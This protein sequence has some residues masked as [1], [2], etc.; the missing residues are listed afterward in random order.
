MPHPS[1]PV[2]CTDCAFAWNSATMVDGL[3]L[4]GSCP[5]CG[6]ALSFRDPEPDQDRADE[7]AA[8][9]RS[10][11]ERAPHLVLGLPRR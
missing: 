10:T 9:H 8:P 5:R 2:S 7:P 11:D 4:I 6:G 3:R 1:A